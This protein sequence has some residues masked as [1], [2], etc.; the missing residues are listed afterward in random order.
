MFQ[1]ISGETFSRFGTVWK[2]LRG[3]GNS[4]TEIFNAGIF[5]KIKVLTGGRK[6]AVPT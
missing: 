3:G 1:G 6:R 5:Q 2:I 4:S